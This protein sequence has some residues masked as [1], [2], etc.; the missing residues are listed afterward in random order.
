MAR[1]AAGLRDGSIVSLHLG[2]PGS[3]A[4]IDRLASLAQAPGLHPVLLRDLIG[5][6]G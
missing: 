3:V 4:A 6:P 2:H 1:V 5:P